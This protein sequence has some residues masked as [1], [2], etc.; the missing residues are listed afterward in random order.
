[1]PWNKVSKN[2]KYNSKSEDGKKTDFIWFGE[3]D[4]LFVAENHEAASIALPETIAVME[5]TED[6]PITPKALRAEGWYDK[7]KDT[8]VLAKRIKRYDY[9]ITIN[10]YNRDKDYE[11]DFAAV[12]FYGCDS[13]EKVNQIIAML[14]GEMK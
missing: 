2:W 6:Q 13:M 14:E 3:D 4:R 10:F 1:M 7:E 12:I 5:F 8:T 11:V 9:E